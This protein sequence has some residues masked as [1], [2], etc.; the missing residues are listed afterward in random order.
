MNTIAKLKL[1]KHTFMQ[2][3]VQHWKYISI[4]PPQ[5]NAMNIHCYK[6]LAHNFT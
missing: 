6:L 5:C 2:Y 4:T 3:I 1:R